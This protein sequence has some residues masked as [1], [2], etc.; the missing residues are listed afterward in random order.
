MVWVNRACDSPNRS[1]QR[2]ALSVGR[3]VGPAV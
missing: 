2:P 3:A 1:S